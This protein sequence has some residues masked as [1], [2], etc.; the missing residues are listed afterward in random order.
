MPSLEGE[1]G[2]SRTELSSVLAVFLIAGILMAP[3]S[4]A[5]ADSVGPRIPIMV[6]SILM[7]AI[8]LLLA[9]QQLSLNSL[10]LSYGLIAILGAG[11]NTIVFS[12]LIANWF[13]TRA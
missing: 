11:T 10:R 13:Y 7:S 9:R 5:I 2:W 12:R 8:F 3:V 1:Y 4:G 6:S